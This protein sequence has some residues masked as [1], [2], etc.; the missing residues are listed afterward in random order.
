MQ[1]IGSLFIA[2]F[3]LFS[4]AHAQTADTAITHLLGRYT[5]PEGSVVSAVVVTLDSGKL[6]MSSEA[7]VSDLVKLGDDQYNIVSFDGTAR[8]TRDSSSHKI[9]GVIIDARG[10]HL[11][12]VKAAE[13]TASMSQPLAALHKPFLRLQPNGDVY[14]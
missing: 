8:F 12:G 5:F 9:I 2:A 1:K 13:N 14:W 10:Y 6:T 4:C 11:E 3:F 7:G